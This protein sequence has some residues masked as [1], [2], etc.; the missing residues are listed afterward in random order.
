M[1][2]RLE[3]SPQLKNPM[4][5]DQPKTTFTKAILICA[6]TGAF[7]IG[8]SSG[9]IPIEPSKIHTPLW[10]IGMA[11][12]LFWLAALALLAQNRPRVNNFLG[13]LMLFGFAGIG[14]WVAVLGESGQLGGGMPMLSHQTNI[15]FARWLFGG[16]A[17]ICLALAV[18]AL[19]KAL[20][21]A[22]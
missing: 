8:I 19:K 10:V 6:L 13:A 7:L 16:G 2:E 15:S 11:G 4:N 3:F 1:A 17:L 21:R 18:Y 9:L 12:G 14:G 22:G 5:S 20:E